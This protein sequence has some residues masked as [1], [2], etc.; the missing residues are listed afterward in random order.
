MRKPDQSLDEYIV[1]PASELASGPPRSVLLWRTGEVEVLEP[2]IRLEDR[3]KPARTSF[4]ASRSYQPLWFRRFVAVGS[5]ALVLIALVLM[6][7]I[8]VGINDPGSGTDVAVNWKLDSI[9]TG[10]VELFTLDVSPPSNFEAATGGIGIVGSSVRRRS[11]RARTNLT[12]YRSKRHPG[13][14]PQPEDPKFVPTTLVIY[15]ENGVINT[16]IEPWLQAVNRKPP[17]FNN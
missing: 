9:L 3:T 7:A 4:R 17:T 14:L 10:P 6:S 2:L 16:R 5:G 12:A 8:L 15:P 13:P 11:A 1:R